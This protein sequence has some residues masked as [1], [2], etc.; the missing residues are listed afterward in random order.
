[1]KK[2]FVTVFAACALLAACNNDHTEETTTSTDTLVTTTETVP[3]EATAT[4]TTTRTVTE[5]DVMYTGGRMQVY[6]NNAWVDANEDVTL[7]NGTVVYTDGRVVRDGNEYEWEEGYVVDRDGN[8][9]DKTGNAIGD[10]WDATKH[11]VKK[12]GKAVGKA[13]KKVGEKA[14]DAVD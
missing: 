14:K 13:A 2:I 4:T 1:M 11:G 9:W 8:V 3:V 7:S 6:R 10:A 12:A 5:G